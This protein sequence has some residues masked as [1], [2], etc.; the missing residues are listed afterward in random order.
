VTERDFMPDVAD[1][2]EFM[3]EPDFRQRFGGPGSPEYERMVAD[4][5]LRLTNTA[6]FR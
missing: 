6:L 4:I 3:S 1:L 2:P 5:E